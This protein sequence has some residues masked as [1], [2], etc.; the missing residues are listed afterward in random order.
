M[1]V[2]PAVGCRSR[3]VTLLLPLAVLAASSCSSGSDENQ[4]AE[5]TLA[6]I[7]V[8]TL[9]SASLELK[10]GTGASKSWHLAGGQ[11]QTGPIDLALTGADVEVLVT[12]DKGE[13]IRVTPSAGLT[14]GN[15]KSC[16]RKD[17]AGTRLEIR[18]ADLDDVRCTGNQWE[19]PDPMPVVEC[20]SPVIFADDFEGADN[21]TTTFTQT[22]GS[23]HTA[24]L[25][26]SGGNPLGYR[27]MVH[28]LPAPGPFDLFVEH[29]FTGGSYDPAVQGA[30]TLVHYAED[31]IHLNPPYV[32]S[33][34]GTSFWLLQNGTRRKIL[35]TGSF[36]TSTTWETVVLRNLTA[37]DFPGADFTTSGPVIEFGYGR[38][39]STIAGSPAYSL[40]HGIDNWTVVV[41]H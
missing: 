20:V 33:Q 32:G 13:E 40:E 28:V 4:T 5:V 10:S 25:L 39:N 31:R 38:A 26:T 12:L 41:C 23:S 34:I 19:T 7:N 35:L 18:V 9:P 24:T 2:Q 3:W 30:I 36:F 1:R 6:L 11:S 22:G 16:R 37:A 21:F 14:V 17:G 15:Q 27:H 8:N 29:L